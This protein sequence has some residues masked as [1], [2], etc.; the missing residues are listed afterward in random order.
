ML[1]LFVRDNCAYSK[2]ALDAALASGLEV[3]IC[4]K[5]ENPAFEEE[6]QQLQGSGEVPYLVDTGS[7]LVIDE[8]EA[9]VHYF[10]SSSNAEPSA[11]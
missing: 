5:T 7:G 11:T 1:K 8:S 9:I 2:R 3:R 4:N 6:L 10:R